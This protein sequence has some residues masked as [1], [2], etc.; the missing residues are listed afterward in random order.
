M[1]NKNDKPPLR[2][3]DVGSV[4]EQMER[5]FRFCIKQGG[6]DNCTANTPFLTHSGCVLAWAQMPYE[7]EWKDA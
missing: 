1:M 6:C 2:N 3:C 7:S 5:H 4:S